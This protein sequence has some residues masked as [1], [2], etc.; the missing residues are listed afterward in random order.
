MRAPVLIVL[1]V[2]VFASAGQAGAGQGAKQGAPPGQK[3]L[4]GW[5]LFA[6]FD[7]GRGEWRFVLL[8]GS[9][10][11]KTPQEV[12]DSLTLAGVGA[13]GE[14]L[15]RLAAGESVLVRDRLPGKVRKQVEDLCTRGK[16][17]FVDG[18]R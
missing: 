3:S 6:R 4:K 17:K 2:L 11:L 13:L 15:S 14:G 12:A 18:G 5:E 9:N 7:A 16:L 8:P 10:R 1:A